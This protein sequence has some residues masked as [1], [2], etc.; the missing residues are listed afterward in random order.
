MAVGRRDVAFLLFGGEDPG[1]FMVPR[2]YIIHVLVIPGIL[3]A[4]IG[5]H[6]IFVFWQ[7]HT[8]MPAKNQ[9]NRIETGQPFYPYF[10]AKT[11]AWFFFVFAVC[12]LLATFAQ[13][14][15]IWQYGP[16]TPVSISSASHPDFY[17]G[18][19]ERSLR[20]IPTWAWNF[21]GHTVSF[22]LVAPFPA[23]SG[24]LLVVL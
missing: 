8:A 23:T 18:F 10:L 7:S 16:Y 13:I 5:A 4:L 12:A 3:L 21:L 11:T 22:T 17:M 19:L 1:T 9:T 15:P 6:V 24:I 2:M 20:M 14:N